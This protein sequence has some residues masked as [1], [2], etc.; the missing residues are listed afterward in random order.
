MSL[1]SSNIEESSIYK[2]VV[3]AEEQYS[4]WPEDRANALGWSDAG[5]SGTKEECLGYI[6]EVWTDMR[7][8]SLRKRMEEAAHLDAMQGKAASASESVPAEDDLLKRLSRQQQAVEVSLRPE[9]SVAALH[10]RIQQG[11][12][13]IRFT[14]TQGG[15]ELGIKL[16]QESVRMEKADFAKGVGFVHLEGTLKLNY[17]NVRCIADVDLT[18]LS[19]QGHLQLIES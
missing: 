4:I 11:H 16:N 9:K 10:K 2:V 1:Y 3:N 18:T 8:L 15:T 5:K 17:Q 7:P 13:Y 12:V 14:G 6:R 19:G